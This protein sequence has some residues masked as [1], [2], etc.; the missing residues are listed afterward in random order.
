M[1]VPWGPGLSGWCCGAVAVLRAAARIPGVAALRIWPSIEYRQVV[2][3]AVMAR[4]L[5][6]RQT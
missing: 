2:L 1:A 5:V 4:P 6:E 3:S